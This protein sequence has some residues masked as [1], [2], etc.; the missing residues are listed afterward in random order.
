MKANS[1]VLVAGV[2]LIVLAGVLFYF[3]FQRE[4]EVGSQ[5]SATP[6]ISSITPSDTGEA[7][8]EVPEGW[9]T[10]T[11]NNPQYTISY[12]SE[13]QRNNPQ[14]SE[15]RF[16]LLG[17]TQAEGTEIFDG[18]SLSIN[19]SEYQENNFDEF[20]RREYEEIKT[21][22]TTSEISELEEKTV[23]VYKGYSFVSES[24]GEYTHIYLPMENN[25]FMHIYYIAPDPENVGYQE[26][27][28]QM[29]SSLKF[30]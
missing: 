10:Y 15:V 12:P 29:L 23:A 1:I 11:N 28:N 17:E 9:K 24:L 4:R 27:V 3:S 18:I 7:E 13:M 26:T 20:A 22:P 16:F 30:D 14:M 6:S 19:T 2:V 25:M 21:D 8:A 5:D